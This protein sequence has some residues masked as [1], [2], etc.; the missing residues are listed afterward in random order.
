MS[1][2]SEAKEP[3]RDAAL[4]IIQNFDNGGLVANCAKRHHSGRGSLE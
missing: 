4:A 1:E 2:R 3:S